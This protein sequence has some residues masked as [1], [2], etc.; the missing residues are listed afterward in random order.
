MSIPTREASYFSRNRKYRSSPPVSTAPRRPI[1]KTLSNF[2]KTG[3]KLFAGKRWLVNSET[4][5][6]VPN[7]SIQSISSNH[8]QRFYII[9]PMRNFQLYQRKLR[10]LMMNS[11]KLR[12]V[13]NV[14]YNLFLHLQ[15]RKPF[16]NC[17]WLTPSVPDGPICFVPAGAKMAHFRLWKRLLETERSW[18][19]VDS[20]KT[21]GG[22]LCIING[23]GNNY[24]ITQT[25]TVKK[26]NAMIFGTFTSFGSVNELRETEMS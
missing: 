5:E 25:L 6:I 24:C 16:G 1:C 10:K 13:E 21:S 2:T 15:S 26:I 23:S 14:Q 18:N 4:T 22:R 9:S 19:V 7:G 8:L 17:Q 11:G 3:W 12:K 20:D